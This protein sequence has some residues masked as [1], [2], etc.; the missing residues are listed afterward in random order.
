VILLLDE[1]LPARVADAINAL[2]TVEA[3]HVTKFLPRGATDL[4]VF[5][6]LRGREDWVLITQ[7][8]N[9]RKRPQ[10][11]AALR[12][13]KVGAFVLTGKANRTVE[14]MLVLLLQSL[15]QMRRLSGS[16]ARPFIFGITDRRRFERLA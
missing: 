4:Q 8:K 16:T 11:L 5:E 12:A 15:D 1:N 6:F 2:G 3:N 14:K 10:E 9:I 13:A 7:D